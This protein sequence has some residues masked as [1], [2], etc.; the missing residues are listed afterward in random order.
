MVT[1]QVLKS[2]EQTGSMMY[3]LCSQYFK[4]LENIALQ[5]KNKKTPTDLCNLSL[6]EYYNYVRQIPYKMDVKPIEVIGRPEKLVQLPALDCKKKAVLIG[7]YCTYH[8]I[9]FRFIACSSRADKN[10][11]HV[12]PEVFLNDNWK[13][14]D[15]TYNNYYIGMRKR[16][17]K[18]EVL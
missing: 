13:T 17:T 10:I 15:A 5:T 12:Y 11:H 14:F 9:P 16:Y 3:K 8:N 7:S 2:K 18:K 1:K 6:P 4:D